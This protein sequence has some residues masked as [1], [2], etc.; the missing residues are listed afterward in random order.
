M[1]KR[2]LIAAPIVAMGI[3]ALAACSPAAT[4]V[5]ATKTPA[6]ALSTTASSAPAPTTTT[7]TTPPAPK[8]APAATDTNSGC[9]VNPAN[10]P[11]PTAEPAEWVPKADQ[12]QV[13]L[14]PAPR[15]VRV[16]GAP[17]EVDVT[18]C[19]NSPVAYPSIGF[20]FA[21]ERCTCAP[22]PV[23]IARGTVQRYD[24]GQWI[25]LGESSMGTGMDYVTQFSDQQPL[26]KGKVVTERF[27]FTY[28]QSMTSGKGG[29]IGAIVT[30][31]GPHILGQT[32][33]S[34]PVSH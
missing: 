21:L 20:V 4:P 25:S 27:R 6:P 24:H 2:A 15:S 28:D 14:S 34:F 32:D 8:G 33:L 17:V 10:A 19:N 16:G 3:A 18:V 11:V 29:V 26:P 22:E 5:A 1:S 9:K 7:T 23:F 31:D 13:S 30:P 12:V